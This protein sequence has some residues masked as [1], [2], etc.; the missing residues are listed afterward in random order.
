MTVNLI[1]D[2]TLAPS[3]LVRQRRLGRVISASASMKLG[4][5][6]VLLLGVMAVV[7]RFWTPYGPTAT[8]TGP[9]Y[10]APSLGHPF[11]TDSVGTDIFSQTLAAAGEDMGLTLAAVIIAFAV[12][13]VIGAVAGFAGGWLDLVIMRVME[14]LQAFPALLLAMLMVAAVG[15][16]LVNVLFVVAVLGIP[17]YV[18]LVR[19][20]ILSKKNW[21]FAEAARMVGNRPARVLFRHLLP[22]SL[23]PPIAFSSVNASWVTVIIAS[24]GFIGLGIEPGSAEWGS[25]IS[26][27]QDAIVTGQWWI[28]VFPG[29]GILLL[30][31][32]FYLIGDGLSDATG[33]RRN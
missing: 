20:E 15:A 10:A 6:V 33:T 28:S 8:G 4:I 2:N 29:L 11:G 3:P 1:P 19:A 17:N 25:M 26:R 5:A 23:T 12:G 22:N 27:G 13:T 18:R 16:G 24:L 21:Q 30:S 7:G 31:G 9:V 14:M 32:A